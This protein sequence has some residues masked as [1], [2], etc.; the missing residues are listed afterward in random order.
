MTGTSDSTEKAASSVTE[1]QLNASL[2]LVILYSVLPAWMAMKE[3]GAT[4]R[5]VPSANGY[6]GTPMTGATRLMNQFGRNGVI[7]RNSM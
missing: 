7:R 1:P 2:E 5:N 4:P 3:G 6:S